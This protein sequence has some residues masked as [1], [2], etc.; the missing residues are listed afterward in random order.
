MKRKF[1]WLGLLGAAT[2]VALTVQPVTVFA[3]DILDQTAIDNWMYKRTLDIFFMYMLVAFLMLY[4]KRM[5]WI[6]C[7][8]TMITL[9]VSLPWYAFL[10]M[11]VFKGLFESVPGYTDWNI[12]F[13]AMA[14]V[15]SITLVIAIGVPLGQVKHG[16]YVIMALIFPFAF[17]ALEWWMF[18]RLAGVLDAG[19]SILVHML[20]AY[21]GWGIILT[22][23][24]KP[25]LTADQT[26]TIH[27]VSFVWLA[28]MLLWVLWPSFVTVLLAP[29]DVSHTVITTY[30]A[31]FGSVLVTYV[32]LWLIDKKINPIIYTYAMLAGLVSIGAT[33]NLV[34]PW[35]GFGIGVGAGIISTL[36]FRYLGSWMTK[37]FGVLDAMGVNSLHGV[38]GIF[39]A[40]VCAVM[41][42]G[43]V[44]IW[45]LLGCM[46]IGLVFGGVTGL[47]CRSPRPEAVLNDS[48]AFALEPARKEPY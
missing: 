38:G 12:S 7:L 22:L 39:G 30:M 8:A 1:I 31:G 2:V 15:M 21:F 36:S 32:L 29:E 4:I 5:E 11:V 35:T 48:E 9:A 42:A 19:G 3:H 25:A 10:K 6:V 28:A 45:A 26:S 20:A 40:L 23:R 41:F 43:V 17:I 24:N 33:C 47:L 46:V 44:E 27:S 16:H 37:T 14:V 34:D 13:L 18:F